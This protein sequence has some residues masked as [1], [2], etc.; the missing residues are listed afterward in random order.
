MRLNLTKYYSEINNLLKI[1]NNIKK[2]I[3][4]TANLFKKCNAKGGRVVFLEMVV[5]HQLQTM[6]Q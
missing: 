1:D 2:K 3:S 4:Q 6:F 5:V